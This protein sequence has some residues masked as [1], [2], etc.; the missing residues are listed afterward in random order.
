MKLSKVDLECVNGNGWG[1][2]FYSYSC[3]YHCKGCFN[4]ELW[5]DGPEDSKELTKDLYYKFY[6]LIKNQSYVKHIAI[7]GGEPLLPQ[8]IS[9]LKNFVLFMKELLPNIK[10]YIWTGTTFENLLAASEN[11]LEDCN[12]DVFSSLGWTEK[13]C[14]DL[15]ILLY[16]IDYLIDGR[17]IQEKKDLTLKWRGSS[18]Q[19]IIQMPKSMYSE[20]AIQF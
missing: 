17:F 1:Y 3:P 13:E 2:S 18:N 4:S 12:D 16:H 8:N 20:K 19:R 15:R 11:R 14:N 5:K 6:H 7:L 9:E 10:I